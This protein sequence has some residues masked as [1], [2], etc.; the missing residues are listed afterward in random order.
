MA[1]EVAVEHCVPLWMH[2]PLMST[3]TMT[4]VFNFQT[5]VFAHVA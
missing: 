1:Y 3:V 2:L 5:L 4:L